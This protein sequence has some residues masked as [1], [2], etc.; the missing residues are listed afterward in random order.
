VLWPILNVLMAVFCLVLAVLIRASAS[1][2]S[3]PAT[4]VEPVHPWGLTNLTTHSFKV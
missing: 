4:S 2:C 3:R 1:G